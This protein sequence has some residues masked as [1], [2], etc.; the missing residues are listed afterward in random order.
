M[1]GDIHTV[2]KGTSV[3]V[4]GYLGT[5]GTLYSFE[6]ISGIGIGLEQG[7]Y[8][9]STSGRIASLNERSSITC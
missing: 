7:K 1:F 4:C 9:K 8:L 3:V 6:T 2:F 5:N